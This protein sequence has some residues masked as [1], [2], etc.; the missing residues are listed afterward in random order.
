MKA[1]NFSRSAIECIESFLTKRFRQVTLN[2]IFSDWI[3]LKHGHGIPQVSVL[4][5]LLFNLYVKDLSNQISENAHI[6]HYADDCLLYCS[7][8][9]SEIALNRLQENIVKLQNYFF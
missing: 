1:I 8:S 3:E 9:E 5:P 4:G 7:D 2:R 6:I